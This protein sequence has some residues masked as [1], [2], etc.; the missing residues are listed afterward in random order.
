[1]E[2]SSRR[3]IYAQET[4]E[5][6]LNSAQ[7]LFCRRGFS[8]TSLDIIA[9]Q[10][11][12]TKGAVY[13]HFKDKRSVFRACFERQA[14]K[15]SAA[16]A[17]VPDGADDWQTAFRQ[18]GAFLDYILRHGKDT[19]ALQEVITVL[20]WEQW[21][22]IDSNH[23]MGH[24]ERTVSRLQ[25]SG[26]MKPYSA[27]VVVNMVYG[28]MVDAAVTLSTQPDARQTEEDLNGLIRDMLLGLRATGKAG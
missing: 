9:A 2:V 16:I 4:R 8:G 21:R 11:Q 12:V 26:E 22:E 19:I 10:A 3:Q 24:I 20:G 27:N 15:V 17:A 23:T 28:L 25:A 13:H 1:M 7:H 18:C 5:A 14:C 6:I